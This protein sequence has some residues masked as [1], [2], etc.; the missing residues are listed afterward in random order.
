MRGLIGIR[1]RM[2]DIEGFEVVVLR[3]EEN[4]NIPCQRRRSRTS[5]LICFYLSIIAS[6]AI[7]MCCHMRMQSRAPLPWVPSVTLVGKDLFIDHLARPRHKHTAPQTVHAA[8]N[9]TWI[10]RHGTERRAHTIIL[11]MRS[12]YFERAFVEN[13][14]FRVRTAWGCCEIG[15]CC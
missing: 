9:D 14:D 15:R 8:W 1:R 12:R 11:S 5:F 13:T 7:D 2:G 10:R 4:E 3:S 6:T